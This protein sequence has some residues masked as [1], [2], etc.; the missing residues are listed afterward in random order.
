[1]H[2]TGTMNY[3]NGDKY[4]GDWIEDNRTGR[5]VYTWA[6]GDRYEMPYSQIFRGHIYRCRVKNLHSAHAITE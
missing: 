4:I 6:D 3:T 2:G 1:M 5:G